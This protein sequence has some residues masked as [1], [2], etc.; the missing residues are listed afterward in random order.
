MHLFR[1]LGS[2][3]LGL[4]ALLE[5]E[6]EVGRLAGLA[7]RVKDRAAILLEDLQPVAEV[8]RMA[9]LRD[10][11]QMR[12]EEGAGQFRNEFFARIGR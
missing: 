10:D 1:C 8:I 11:V 7:G 9:D 5:R 2:R 6:D 4:A 12:A 3:N